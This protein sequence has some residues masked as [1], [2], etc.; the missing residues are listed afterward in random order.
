MLCAVSMS[1]FLPGSSAL[2]SLMQLEEKKKK[3]L[4]TYFKQCIWWNH[5]HCP[6]WPRS[7]PATAIRP[8]MEVSVICL[9]ERIKVVSWIHYSYSTINEYV[10]QNLQSEG[11]TF[12]KLTRLNGL[13]LAYKK[14]QLPARVFITW[15]IP[16]LWYPPNNVFFP[17]FQLF[18]CS[19]CC[20]N[21]STLFTWL[22]VKENFT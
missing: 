21:M 18:S 11:E 19:S 3:R 15:F 5:K 16:C 22:K 8:L 14:L 1:D 2:S 6:E 10:P 20:L 9:C 7:A 4:G 12:L 17:I 13:L